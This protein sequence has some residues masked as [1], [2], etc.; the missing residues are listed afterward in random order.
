MDESRIEINMYGTGYET[1]NPDGRLVYK[2]PYTK[3]Q[4][5]I[6]SKSAPWKITFDI[7]K[8]NHVRIFLRF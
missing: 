3:M 1:I 7:R 2:R 6:S 4:D 8:G 5:N